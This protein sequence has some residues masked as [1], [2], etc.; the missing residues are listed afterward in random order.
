MSIPPEVIV[1]LLSLLGTLVGSMTGILTANKMTNYRIEQ[2]EKKVD[3]H[4]NVIERVALLEQD[5]KQ[6][7]KRLD[8]LVKEFENMKDV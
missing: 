1:G 3:K 2:L 4:N 7:W 6:Q 8:E 5:N